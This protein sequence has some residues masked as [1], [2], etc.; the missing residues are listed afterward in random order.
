VFLQLN[1]FTVAKWMIGDLAFLLVPLGNVSS[2]PLQSS[3]IYELHKIR[4]NELKK[5]KKIKTGQNTLCGAL[6][7]R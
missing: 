1:S 5:E 6:K 7:Y 2:R 4:P 3:G